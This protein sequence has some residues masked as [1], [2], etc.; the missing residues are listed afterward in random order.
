MLDLWT[1]AVRSIEPLVKPA[2]RD[3]WLRPIECLAIDEG[4]IRLRAP[5]RY[6]KEWFEDNFLPSILKDM[7]SRA[8]RAFKVDF[9]VVED[10]SEPPRLSV[11]AAERRPNPAAPAPRAPE[12]VERYTFDKFV[13]GPTNQF[14]HAA[15]R[16][17]AEAP[18]SRWNPLFI[19]GGVGLGKTHLLQAIGHEIHRQHPEWAVCFI[20]CEKFVTDF[21]GSMMSQKRSVGGS[22]MEEFR[23]RYRNAPDVLLVDDIQFLSNKD[24][25]QDE[26][27]HTFN[28]LH[29]AHKQ[30]VL[31]SDKLPAEL[32]G[33]EDRLRSRFTW[34][35]IAEVETPDLETRVAILKRKAEIERVELPDE[36]ALYLAAHIKSNVRELEG[37][38]ARLAARASFQGQAITIELAREAVSKLIATAPS[39]LTIEAVQREVAA[40]FDVKLH[41]LK[42]PKRHRAVAHPRMIAMYLARKLTNMSYPEIGSRFGG[43]DHSTVISAV[44]K[45]ERLCGEDSSVRSVVNTLESHLRQP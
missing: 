8:Q 13:V 26:F 19:Y 45:I 11:P 40:Y 25:S 33:V 3:L 2:H 43:K 4:R 23:A 37:A 17:V 9:E 22:S 36:A 38:L 28:A 35:L 1:E 34:G 20:T 42:G 21:I 39:G 41:D 30:I 12:L 15:A 27:F 44:R 18:A 32:P 10:Q 29:Y 16:M 7:E 5:N 31:A 6:H 24:S 14:A